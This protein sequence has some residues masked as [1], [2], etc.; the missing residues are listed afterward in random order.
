VLSS[1]GQGVFDRMLDHDF[2]EKSVN[3]FLK[4]TP[5]KFEEVSVGKRVLEP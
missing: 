5:I 3:R 4:G 2:I 1:S